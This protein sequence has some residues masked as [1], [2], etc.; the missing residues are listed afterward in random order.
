MNI[1]LI[2]N[3]SYSPNYAP[4]ELAFNETKSWYRK[5]KLRMLANSEEFDKKKYIR[6]A[7]ARV[8]IEHIDNHIR[9]ARQLLVQA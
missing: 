8:P 5:I 6:Q 1:K 9:H 3:K 2:F 4:I 7:F